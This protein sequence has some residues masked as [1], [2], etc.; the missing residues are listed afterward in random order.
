MSVERLTSQKKI[1]LDYLRS[2]KTHPTADAV[3]RAVRKKLP[4]ISKGTVYRNLKNLKQKGEILEIPC[5]VAHFDGDIS[6]HGHFFCER[7]G[8]IFDI[9]SDF[10][11]CQALKNKKLPG[12]IN[13]YQVYFYGQCK[14]CLKKGTKT[15]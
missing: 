9:F 15:K 2:V 8:Q 11:A 6:P 14:K 1:I 4:Q 13:N 10:K 7:C 12:K 5:D 3:Y